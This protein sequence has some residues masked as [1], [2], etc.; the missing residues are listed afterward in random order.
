MYVYC[1]SNSPILY[2]VRAFQDVAAGKLEDDHFPC[3]NKRMYV[4]DGT[5]KPR[6]L[7]FVLGGIS[8]F[9]LLQLT[10]KAKEMNQP[11]TVM[12]TKIFDDASEY[13]NFVRK[14]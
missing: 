11:I 1:T 12:S 8:W 7:I 10:Q 3:V 9:E 5:T 2:Q 13:L 4:G 14:L 6:V